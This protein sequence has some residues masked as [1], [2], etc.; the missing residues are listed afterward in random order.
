[1]F[2]A[3]LFMIDIGSASTA[4]EIREAA[5]VQSAS[6]L[7]G[8]ISVRS[9][10]T[11]NGLD[12]SR[13]AVPCQDGQLMSRLSSPRAIAALDSP[14]GYAQGQ[15]QRWVLRSGHVPFGQV[16]VENVE[17]DKGEIEAQALSQL[18][19]WGLDD[20]EVGRLLVN[21]IAHENSDEVGR[22][23]GH[24]WVVSMDRQLENIEIVGHR[25]IMEYDLSGNLIFASARWP[26]VERSQIVPQMATSGPCSQ[27][28]LE[29]WLVEQVKPRTTDQPLLY[30][31][32]A[33]GKSGD[34]LELTTLALFQERSSGAAH[35]ALVGWACEDAYRVAPRQ[36][37]Q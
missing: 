25:I 31:V 33:P 18:R 4:V 22:E 3:M 2:T 11:L 27:T 20:G 28:G 24:S 36:E 21:M 10:D 26:T 16:L 8:S 9:D 30:P 32:F 1:M 19:S 17:T 29:T 35:G 5:A 7:P 12:L 6:D 14:C 37:K 13:S 23:Y 34:T 15:N